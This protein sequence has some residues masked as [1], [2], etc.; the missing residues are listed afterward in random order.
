MICGG[1]LSRPASITRDRLRPEHAVSFL[2]ASSRQPPHRPGSN[3]RSV[4]KRKRVTAGFFCFFF[5]N[6]MTL[7]TFLLP[8]NPTKDQEENDRSSQLRLGGLASWNKTRRSNLGVSDARSLSPD[9]SQ[10]DL[11]SAAPRALR[12]SFRCFLHP[13][14]DVLLLELEC[15]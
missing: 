12:G 10:T 7:R 1:T 13:D 15:K 11:L 2:S 4:G 9:L 6:R 5:L 3:S 14:P 8:T